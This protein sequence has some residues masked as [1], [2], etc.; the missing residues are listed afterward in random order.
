[1]LKKF[2]LLFILLSGI[3][4][5]GYSQ[6]I[7]NYNFTATGGSFTVIS[8][9]TF[10]AISG[11]NASNGYFNNIPIGFDFWYMGTRYTTLGASTNGWISPGGDITTS[12]PANNLK[13][14]GAPRPIF[15]P[16]WDDLDMQVTSNVSYTTTGTAGSRIFTLQFLDAKWNRTANG[17]VISFQ[18]KLYEST[19]K[20]EYLYRQ[21]ATAVK[22]SKA[23][24]GIAAGAT[25][26]G[27]FLS[28]NGTGTAP[29]ASSVSETTTLSTKPATGQTYSF[30]SPTPSSPSSLIFSNISSTGMTLNWT[31]NASNE[32]G[33]VIYSSTDGVNY[34]FVNQTAANVTSSIYTGLTANTN[35]YWRVYAVTEGCLS[36]V[37]SGSQATLCLAPIISQIPLSG[38]LS[39]YIFNNNA[40][41]AT[42]NNS[43][44]L[45]N[46]P[47]ATTD[48]FGIANRAYNFNGSSQYIS[49]ANAYS[50]P[51]NFS[52]SLW[53]KT[54]SVTG[55]KLIGFGSS[56]TGLSSNYD[57]HI[58]MNNAGQLYFGVYPNTVVTVNSA[59]SYNDNSWHLATAT[60]SSTTGMALYVDGAIVGSN[61]V[62]LS[63]QNYTGYWRI[64]YDNNAGWTSQ[65][66]NFYFNGTLD[67]VL[68][69][70]RALTAGEVNTLYKSPDGAG[71][72]GPVCSGSALSLSA[73]TISGATYAWS[74]PNGFTSNSQNPSLT[75][76]AADAG[77]YNLQVTV[78]GCSATAY[79]N[80]KSTTTTG[81][82]TGAVST[83]WTDIN[84]W[85]SG[86]LPT[87]LIDVTINS[88]AIR[89]PTI[90]S[91]ASC[92]NL[93]INAG[94]T[95]TTS[96]AGTLNIA[97]N[98]VNNGTMT[99]S[100]TT[101]F[102][103]T[104][105][106]QTFAGVTN[107]YNVTL[108][109]TTGL[110]IPA[111][112][113]IVNNLTL[114]SGIFNANNFSLLV[115]GNWTNN[116]S[117]GAYVAGTAS[118][119]FNGTT[120][121]SIGG[122]FATSFNTINI[123][124]VT[125][126]VSLNS[127]VN[128]SGDLTITA[129]T[130]DIGTYTANRVTTGGILT[131]SNNATLKIGGTNTYPSNYTTST[132]VVASTIEYAGT[133]Q[134][135]SNQPYGNLK[136]SSSAGAAV[137]TFPASTLNVA[138][139]LISSVGSGTSVTF[140]TGANLNVGDT[141]SIGA[142]TT[143]N[144][145]S[146]TTSVGGAWVNNGTFNGN[147]GTVNFVG[148]GKTVGG[149]G[150]QNFNSLTVAA[151]LVSFSNSSLTLTGNL[152]TTG[153]GSFA[154][155]SGGTLTMTGAGTTISGTGISID[156]LTVS[157]TVSTTAS[158]NITGNL[159]V[160]GSFT[161]TSGTISLTGTAKS[162]TGT[163]S[164]SF[165]GLSV[166]G[167]NT[168]TAN[169]S[170]G[171]ALIVGGSFTATA[172]T[173]TFT[174][175]STLSGVAN[176]FNTTVNGTS[177]QLSANAT[178]G[179]A[180]ALTITS[181]ILNTTSSIP[182]IVNFNG[183]IAQTVNAISYNNLVLSNGNNKT[184]AAAITINGNINIAVAT[185]FIAGA[186]T[187][188]LYGNWVNAGTF[189]ASAGTVQ[190][191]GN[192]IQNV[193]GATT[194][195]TIIVNHTTPITGLV[196]QSNVGVATLNMT[197]GNMFTGA[198]IITL[199]TTRT[200]PGI[201]L[202]NI[203]RTHSFTTGIAYAFEGP[204]N[205][206]TFAS[207]TGVTSIT[208][209]VI[210]GAVTDFPLGSAIGRV[211]NI[212]VPAGTYNAT[213]RLHYED[214]ELNG[215]IE[216]SMSLWR[217]NGTA[218]NSSGKTGNSSTTNYVEQ[219]D[220]NDITNRWSLSD[221]INS[222]RWNGSVSSNWNTA[223]N[224]TIL[225]GSATRPPSAI[226]NVNIGD[227]LFVNQPVISSTVNVKSI[228]LSS[229]K[230]VNLSMAAGGTL[231]TGGILGD[232]SSNAAHSINVNNQ[233]ISVN[234]D[235]LL[236]N[237]TTG[238]VINLNIGTGN[239]SVTGSLTQNADAAIAFGGAGNM[240]VGGNY[241][242]V[243]GSFTA[244]TGTFTYNGTGNQIVGA[245]N[246]NNV[247]VNK[248][249]GISTISSALTIGGNLLVSSGELDNE[250]ITSVLGN[251]TIASGAVLSNINI[252]KVGGNWL[253]NGTFTGV[254]VNI[255]FNGA[256][257]QTISSSTFNNLEINK[258]V[259]STAILT[260]AVTLKGN[261]TGTSGTLDISN[262]FF[263]RDVLGG[264]A[265]MADSCTLLVGVDNAPNKFSS[266]SLSVG[267]TIV[268]NGTD[269]QHLLL[270]GVVYGN[271]IFRNTG[272]KLLYTPITVMGKLTI[273]NTARFSAGSNTITLYGNF[274]NDG[275][276]LPQT[277]T[278]VCA[279]AGKTVSGS[280]TF[281][282]MNISGTYTFL[283]D[284][285]LNDKLTITNAGGMTAGSTISMTLN[286]DLLNTGDVYFL[287]NVI[288]TGNAPQTLSLINAVR[289]VAV[290]VTFNGTVP[291]LMVSTS[292]PQFGFLNVNNTGGVNPSVGWTVLYGMTVGAGASFNGGI[293]SH[294]I[295]GYLTNNGTITSTGTIS[296]LPSTPAI[297]NFGSNFSSTG[298]ATFGGA[299]AITI[300]GS[301]V[302][303]ANV[304]VSNTNVSGITP[305]SDWIVTKVFRINSGSTFN[306]SNYNYTVGGN[307]MVNGT[308]NKGTSNFIL[309]GSVI[310]DIFSTSAFNNLTVNKTFD[311]TTISSNISV[312]GNLN[313]TSGK[314][315][316]G[317]YAVGI[318]SGGI[319]TGAAQ[320]TG[321]VYGNLQKNVGT[322]TV[323]R[324]FEIGDYTNYT[325][326]TTAFANV[327]ISGDLTAST[328][329]ADHPNISTSSINATRSINRYWTLANSG[330][331]FNNYTATFNYAGTDLDAGAT[332]AAIDIENYNGSSWIIPTTT[333]RNS[334]NIT[335]T[336]NTN[337][338][339]FTAGEICNKG[340][341]ISYIGS[342]FCTEAG[343]A[344]ATLIGTTGGVYS[345]AAGLDINATTG[346]INLATSLP[347]TYT[348]TYT[349]AAT[350]SC[351]QFITKT[352]VTIAIAGTWT[353]VVNND[354]NNIGNWAC[355]GIPTATSNVTIPRGLAVYPT[356]NTTVAVNNISIENSSVLTLTGTLRI[357]GSITNSG[358][359][360]ADAGTIEMI[361]TS[362]QVIPINAFEEN[363]LNN[364]I[365][366]N[367]SVAGVSLNG[368]LD[369][370]GS[371][372]Y[373]GIGK[374]F[375]TNDL[376]T[377]KST[378]LNTAWVGDMT[379]NSIV[380]KVTVE[381]FISA[382]KAWRYLSV[383]TN[384]TQTF[385]DTWQEGAAT[386]SDNLTNNYGIQLTSNRSSWAADGFDNSSG[387]PSIK[388]YVPATNAFVGITSTNNAMNST[389]G[390]MTFI[391][392][393][394]T[395]ISTATAPTQTV[396]RTTGY[397]Y[398]GD[399]PSIL[400]AANKFN[401]V[402]NPFA[403][404][405]D[406]RNITKTGL[407]DFYYLWDPKMG[408][409]YG[410]GG[411][412]VLS[413]DISNNY[414]I[415]PGGGSYGTPGS[416]NNT[417]QSGQ[418]FFIQGGSSGGSITLKEAAKVSNSVQAFGTNATAT[419]PG[420]LR[421]TLN[422]INPDSSTYIADGVSV[423]FDDSYSNA[424]DDLDAAKT[425]NTGE[426]LAIKIEDKLFII[427]RRSSLSTADTI[428]LNFANAK[429]QQYR[430]AI[431]STSLAQ[432]GLIG[433]LRDAY[434]N[435]STPLNVDGLTT[436]N[437]T[438]E[439][440]TGSNAVNRFMIVFKAV[441][442]LPLSITNVDAVKQNK[443]ILVSWKTANE[444]HLKQY[445]I[446]RS[447]DGIFFA[448]IHST[449]AHNM[450]ANT[451]N[452]LDV[453]PIQN[454]NYYRIKSIGINGQITYSDVVK[455]LM[456]EKAK[457]AVYPNPI[458]NKTINLQWG[459]AAAGMY[460]LRVL[461]SAGQV[462]FST[463]IKHTENTAIDR[464]V[465][466][467]NTDEGIH[468]LEIVGPDGGKTNIQIA[469]FK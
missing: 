312:T 246:Y 336:G 23:S 121:Q 72:N 319:V 375:A 39:N 438:T 287:G 454:C 191:L 81:Q 109:N 444:V 275:T 3:L 112:T 349:I 197:Q 464:I 398:T 48:R 79:T 233:N 204:D 5:S 237:G 457:M 450:A 449:A 2:T 29:V 447:T 370:Y 77:V 177:L 195:N 283:S 36:N 186:F 102:N 268:F 251:V 443:Q 131:V 180:S 413:K 100:G 9:A 338:G 93:T 405:I 467:D 193:T 282:K 96:A 397:L 461:N 337:F 90:S 229:T 189:T 153:S 325:P 167:S 243:S 345:A 402:G 85:C 124:N 346:S 387:S 303:F 258:P 219:S 359:F 442:E 126:T 428:F 292:A 434:T 386:S 369:I 408:G 104:G 331:L 257:T 161:G 301:P 297:V 207:V 128:I 19:G 459:S 247:T 175:S 8:G 122:S 371:L 201:I 401:G 263:N 37:L 142:A 256:G 145:G 106:Q 40:A 143:F 166:S 332:A 389:D 45:Q 91:S 298:R 44:T 1:M 277:S 412:Q 52:I 235:L 110:L 377:L 378:A 313:F 60:F 149:T 415:T 226:D 51:N 352:T 330:I 103:G 285:T 399:Q 439:N 431:N 171:S 123:N 343:T 469:V 114:S 262:Y 384:S 230:V 34:T 194:F 334:T 423:D 388:T 125:N 174:G 209:S 236:S 82:W 154:Q 271:L 138:G 364:L 407:R 238:R 468:R 342:P 393:D 400:I 152:A 308:L 409:L 136:L 315:Y 425:G 456:E 410:Y 395:V 432:P 107:F 53:F 169:F 305:S 70:Q 88:S 272:N 198:N 379:G 17:N 14:G 382:R 185:T 27:N 280:T 309:N 66:S 139:K 296:F 147:S 228:V 361:G 367:S 61:S 94:A 187:H 87:S 168:S 465:L 115:G 133:N 327:T 295:N 250:S 129:G 212:L 83:D 206:I 192:Q 86:V 403:S 344:T 4:L 214:D 132:L 213:L 50:N 245:V 248:A 46:S 396:L 419:N 266:Y 422:G 181:G 224:W 190:F 350:G 453:N 326:L 414:V 32:Q 13:S 164:L 358:S 92:K 234:G 259:G 273:E 385:K 208:V 406:V 172:G 75:Y 117:T 306:A 291:P 165:Y 151:A 365:I 376:L 217:Y 84:N 98:I 411:Y 363:S 130:F 455:V 16:L 111:A 140:T 310:Q 360:I 184:A 38:I 231:N 80:V 458:A 211:Y 390:Y 286:G 10:P 311:S 6:N 333:I 183:A 118:V 205:S 373:N 215:N 318:S 220:L 119:F 43:G 430:F 293:S 63:S 466:N 368:A 232:W 67:D 62:T 225:D 340:T 11:G 341:V 366:S 144:G 437:F 249:S 302:S 159:L 69:Y 253:N 381:R 281:N 156:N 264:T 73:T 278:V 210:K 18:I 137:K 463:K 357:A 317:S 57:R 320:N 26:S 179:I 76:L 356:I 56:Q 270:P 42:G 12:T 436:I 254:G 252:L 290:T 155:A 22:S 304:T 223:A 240:S 157:G 47:T 113:T 95:V 176:L 134:T 35:Y 267:S 64:G 54:A 68:I 173:A 353:G 203:Q 427:E 440:I 429:F 426:N 307:I 24:I 65:P 324:T 260:G 265:T 417:I 424:I 188:S 421:V 89:M 329:G 391:R 335:C 20:I 55:G 347:G 101:I 221:A 33:F 127:N 120:A 58:Y 316:T 163:G 15:A 200:G 105:A 416:V 441:A 269:T 446:E 435:T 284:L 420:N 300:L 141:I 445:D 394:R 392:G 21:E 433:F 339:D 328:T 31:D 241:N 178:L 227:T 261:L 289:T 99:N 460:N 71:N 288:F 160:S 116:M 239:L 216:N 49:T 383:P 314:I 362:S 355:G 279:G 148:A 196:L 97:G 276:F 374:T 202:G 274:Q 28:L 59:L 170:V 108:N 41:D 380:G 351:N 448:N 321:W 150:V 294:T 451:Y 25:G 162:M 182:N 299:G 158:L 7:T 372:T 322:G 323:T 199:T 418:A 462:T 30:L 452:W 146:F 354:W 74:G 222:V 255:V 78:G 244:S 404:A 135:V 242:Y 218:W 348:V